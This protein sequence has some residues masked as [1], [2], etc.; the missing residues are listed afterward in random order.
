MIKV[1]PSLPDKKFSKQQFN[2]SALL[3][4]T[5]VVCYLKG[6]PV[7]ARIKNLFSNE[8]FVL[9]MNGVFGYTAFTAVIIVTLQLPPEAILDSGLREI[10]MI[11]EGD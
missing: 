2:L 6:S 3:N 9:L 8:L 4:F 10:L 5:H 11:F 1:F 7:K